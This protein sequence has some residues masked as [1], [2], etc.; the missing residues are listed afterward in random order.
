MRKICY[1]L[2]TPDVGVQAGGL[3]LV[4]ANGFSIT[5]AH[6]PRAL[7]GQRGPAHWNGDGSR[8]ARRRLPV[9]TCWPLCPSTRGP[10]RQDL[11]PPPPLDSV[12]VLAGRRSRRLWSEAGPLG[13]HSALSPDRPLSAPPQSLMASEPADQIYS[14]GPF[15]RNAADAGRALRSVRSPDA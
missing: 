2:T 3:G 6:P 14:T 10:V 8:Q 11:V 1:S 9:E 5:T 12:V 7:N 13:A 15:G 4:P